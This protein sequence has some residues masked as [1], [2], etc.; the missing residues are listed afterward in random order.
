MKKG[1]YI[2]MILVFLVQGCSLKTGYKQTKSENIY[3][4]DEK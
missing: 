4:G 2:L 3:T 1:F